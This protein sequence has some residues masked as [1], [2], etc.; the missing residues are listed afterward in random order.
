MIFGGIHPVFVPFSTDEKDY[1]D[2]Y[3][4]NKERIP[5]DAGISN[6]GFAVDVDFS[7]NLDDTWRQDGFGTVTKNFEI[8]ALHGA[9][10]G[11]EMD[12]HH[13]KDLVVRRKQ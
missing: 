8:D 7:R 13:N 3:H 9:I 12:R 10:S 2:N 4:G 1:I 5:E 11:I 6:A